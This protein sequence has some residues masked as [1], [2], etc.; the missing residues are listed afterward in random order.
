MPNRYV[1]DGI[2]SSE[3]VNKLSFPA[4]VFFRRLVL[5]VDDFGL[6]SANLTFL[7]SSLYP[8]KV[9]TVKESHIQGWLDE[10]VNAGLVLTYENEGKPFLVLLNVTDR[11]RS[12]TTKWA[13]PPLSIWP[14]LHTN[15]ST[16]LQMIVHAL[17]SD[18]V[19]DTV[20]D[21]R[22]N[23]KKVFEKLSIPNELICAEFQ[24]RLAT[25]VDR[26]MGMG[27]KPQSGWQSFF[28][29][30]VDW[31]GGFQT[32]LAIEIISTSLR[33]NW[34]GLFVPKHSKT[35]ATRKPN[36]NTG[37]LNEHS[38]STYKIKERLRTS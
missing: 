9:D 18:S 23:S 11:P 25:W 2:N 1:R 36:S 29:E 30:Q 26:R 6:Y 27:R 17:D 37:T 12:K 3:K 32:P 31:L 13:L 28:Q 4:E 21:K 22:L 20:S 16:C 14:R 34:Q 15:V 5:E 8:L 7:R 19:T 24:E 10:C 35:D 38:K 33:N